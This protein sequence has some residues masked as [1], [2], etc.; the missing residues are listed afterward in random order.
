[1]FVHKTDGDGFDSD[2]EVYAAAKAADAGGVCIC[3]CVRALCVVLVVGLSMLVHASSC[4][5]YC[6]QCYKC[7]VGALRL[8]SVIAHDFTACTI[9]T[10]WTFT[11]TYASYDLNSHSIYFTHLLF[12]A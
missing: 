4:Y 8:F 2:S 10:Q 7:T 3:V 9:C 5:C 1:M 12:I 11:F 6:S